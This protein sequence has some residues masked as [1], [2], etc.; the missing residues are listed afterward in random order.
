[1]NDEK[2]L[3]FSRFLKFTLFSIGSVVIHFVLLSLLSLI[4]NF[5]EVIIA[6]VALVLSSLWNFAYNRKY[7]FQS[8]GNA[9]VGLLL[10]LAYYVAFAPLAIHFGQ[11][12]LVGVLLWDKLLVLI[13]TMIINFFTEFLFQRFVVFAKS[14]DTNSIAQERVEQENQL[15]QRLAEEKA[16]GTTDNSQT[17]GESDE[18][19]IEDDTQTEQ[20]QNEDDAEVE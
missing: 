8:S 10:T 13:V 5:D 3:E 1:M 7:T 14:I 6:Y 19:I 11:L 4:P 15:A 17:D 12:Y 2:K 16:Q 9:F 18:D 20:S